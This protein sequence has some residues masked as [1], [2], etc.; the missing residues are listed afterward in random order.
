MNVLISAYYSAPC[1]GNFIGTMMDLGLKMRENG[2]K[3]AF[4]FPK[5]ENTVAANSWTEWLKNAGF[6]VSMVDTT[7]PEEEQLSFLK[8]LISALAIDIF[9]I[10]FGLFQSIA[11]KYRAEIP[12]KIIVH[13]HME[14]PAGKNKAIQAL[15]FFR[16]SVLYG[17]NSISI[18][19]V[20]KAVDI[21]H[22]GA[23]HWFLPNGLSMK[24]NLL[25]KESMTREDCR[26]ILG[27]RDDEKL[28]LFLGWDL[29][30]KGLD[31]AVKAVNELRRDDNHVVLGV[32]GL[33][34]F[35]NIHM[36]GM[37]FIRERTEVSPDVEW[38]RYLPSTED[39][40]AY[41]RAAD[42]YLSS[43]RSEAFSYGILE[44]ISQNTPVVVSDIKGT[45]WCSPF[46]KAHFYPVEDPTACADAIQAAIT[47]GKIAANADLICEKYSIDQWCNKM[48]AIYQV[49]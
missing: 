9:H 37:D 7:L 18:V 44:A 6:Q 42:V 22:F 45:K 15:K 13:E 46:T 12:A 16:R 33:G 2:D 48:I 23:R 8:N 3:L 31:I 27:I 17:M 24:R 10:H 30:R 34:S 5:S 20:N 19:S 29:Y 25:N 41:H 32:V 49:Q 38:I 40:F 1:S 14:Y 36:N 21:A 47:Q 11:L 26:H 39:M 43:S 4:V 28:V 35:P